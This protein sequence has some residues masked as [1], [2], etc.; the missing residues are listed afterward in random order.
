MAMRFTTTDK[1]SVSNGVKVLVYGRAGSGKTVL[2]STAPN[3]IILS[4]E[5]GLLSLRKYR[6]PVIE[7]NNVDDLTEAYNWCTS[8]K[9]AGQFQTICLDSISEIAEK[10]L[11]NAKGQVKDPRQ[12]YGELIDKMQMVIRS[13]RD[14]PKHVYFA[15]KEERYKDEGTGSILAGPSMPGSKLGPQL[16]YH[17]D[18]VFNLNIAQN[19]QDKS[20]YRYLRTQPDFNFDAKDRSGALDVIEKPDLSHIINKILGVQK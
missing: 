3:P 17:F 15:A 18:E 8:A 13:F 7:I 12:A 4:A 20:T 14:L 6:I 10:V 11:I 9:E 2:C 19:P 16:P 5:S 1:V